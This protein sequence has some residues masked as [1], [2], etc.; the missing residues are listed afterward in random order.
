MQTPNA[1]SPALD[2]ET[3]KVRD[4]KKEK[5]GLEKKWDGE[6]HDGPGTRI[7][8]IRRQSCTQPSRQQSHRDKADQQAGE[9]VC[10]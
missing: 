9:S 8:T 5:R 7:H 4:K 6:K 2:P 3:D 1:G 10:F